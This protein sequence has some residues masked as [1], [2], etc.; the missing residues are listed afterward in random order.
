VFII[1]HF[2]L[3]N[4]NKAIN[5]GNKKPEESI[6]IQTNTVIH[7]VQIPFLPIVN[8]PC[9]DKVKKKPLYST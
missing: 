6:L 9:S 3:V 8:N 2:K 5:E 4:E 7:P 1:A